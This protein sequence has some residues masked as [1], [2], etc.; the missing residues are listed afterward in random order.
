MSS[1]FSRRKRD[2]AALHF[3]KSFGWQL[4]AFCCLDHTENRMREPFEAITGKLQGFNARD[5][6]FRF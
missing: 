4:F 2:Q 3:S 6:Q 5:K 1:E